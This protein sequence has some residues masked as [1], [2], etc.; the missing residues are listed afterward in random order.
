MVLEF[1]PAIS[2]GALNPAPLPVPAPALLASTVRAQVTGFTGRIAEVVELVPKSATMMVEVEKSQHMY[3][4]TENAW[5]L[6]TPLP[7]I[8]L[9]TSVEGLT[10]TMVF[11]LPVAAFS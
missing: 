3:L 6:P 4:K 5:P 1:H 9:R 10:A 11:G 2:S 7:E 8:T